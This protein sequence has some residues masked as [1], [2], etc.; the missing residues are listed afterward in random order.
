MTLVFNI[1][2]ALL[3]VIGIT[4]YRN[5]IL[6]T[7]IFI[8]PFLTSI[9]LTVFITVLKRR[10]DTLKKKENE[11]FAFIFSENLRKLLA[12]LKDNHNI[13]WNA[14]IQ[15]CNSIDKD[16][17]AAQ[18]SGAE[19]EVEV[20]ETVLK[21]FYR[22]IKKTSDTMFSAVAESLRQVVEYNINT[23]NE[24][25]VRIAVCILQLDRSYRKQGRQIPDDL[26]TYVI[27]RDRYSYEH[28]R[29]IG[30]TY[31]VNANT[32]YLSCIQADN[33]REAYYIENDV[34]RALHDGRYE[35]EDQ[36]EL[37]ANKTYTAAMVVP[38]TQ[39]IVTDK[40]FYGFLS[41]DA[42]TDSNE[43]FV[44]EQLLPLMQ[45]YSDILATYYHLVNMYFPFIFDY[46]Y[47]QNKSEKGG[48][49]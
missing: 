38:I 7:V 9:L 45:T 3:S 27:F 29:Q 8:I 32:P 17:G 20:D 19:M 13:I 21:M 35:C 48:T 10:C 36:D 46:A 22:D 39:N 15:F 34:M 26:H 23:L 11:A 1:V 24:G 18:T 42:V 12:V 33:P 2:S 6:F 47:Q 49:P 40:Y 37:I 31:T 30:E 14:Y 43:T 41:I 4:Q 25:N 16:G 28:A 44:K 5:D